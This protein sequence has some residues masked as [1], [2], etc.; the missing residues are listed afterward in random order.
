MNPEKYHSLTLQ[1]KKDYN[2]KCYLRYKARYERYY[3]T[4][5]EKCCEYAKE[6]LKCHRDSVNAR[7]RLKT[8]YAREYMKLNEI[9]NYKKKPK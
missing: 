8:K 3:A 7:H 4:N 1:E 6:Y 5:R 9:E 2:H